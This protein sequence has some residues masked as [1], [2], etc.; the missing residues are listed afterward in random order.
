MNFFITFIGAVVLLVIF[1]LH[2]QRRAVAIKALAT[3]LGFSSPKDTLP[4]SLS[5]VGTGL[6][7]VNSTWNV[8]EGASHGIRI[9]AFD[10]Q[11]GIGKGSC[12][13]TV[14]AAQASTELFGIFNP[15]F[16]IE[17]SGDWAILYQPRTMGRLPSRLMPVA[18]I[19][20]R[21]SALA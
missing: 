13:R 11:I 19:E 18:E 17:R 9:V 21:L 12:L 15:E 6:E 3:R 5:L 1:Y 16:T 8:I 14:I 2:Y 7:A 4:R 20:A 10:C